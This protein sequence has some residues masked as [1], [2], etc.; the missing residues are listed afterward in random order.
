MAGSPFFS[1][2]SPMSSCAS[3][4]KPP[5]GRFSTWFRISIASSD[6]PASR[7]ALAFARRSA[8]S[9]ST[10]G[11]GGD[12]TARPGVGAAGALGAGGAAAGFATGAAAF[13]TLSGGSGTRMKI[14]R[15]SPAPVTRQATSRLNCTVSVLRAAT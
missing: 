12:G 14:A 2:A 15:P 10:W 5:G 1:R 9:F 13:A 7:A 3:R 8:P 11:E 4:E 6:L